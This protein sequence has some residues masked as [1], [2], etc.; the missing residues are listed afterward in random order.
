MIKLTVIYN[1]LSGADHEAFIRW[2][3][4]EHQAENMAMPGV[5]K[6]DFYIIQEGWPDKE[7][8]YRYMTEAYFPDM[9]TF[10]AAFF[11]PEFN[12]KLLESTKTVA[13]PMFLI[14][15]EV[16]SEVKGE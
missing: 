4:T 14:S 2:R 1:L 6:S 15:E 8:S 5:L 3:T 7:T 13:H 16:I 12:A 10:R 11:E 9:A